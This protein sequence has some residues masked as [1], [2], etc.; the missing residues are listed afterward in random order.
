VRVAVVGATGLVGTHLVVAL[1]GCGD[2]VIALSRRSTSVAG[3]ATTPWDPTRGPFPEAAREGVDAVVNLAGEPL[4]VGRWSA[5]RRARILDSRLAATRG[6]VAALGDPGPT[7]LLNAS[8]VGV[9]GEAEAPV[10]E[11]AAPGTDFLA[12]V[13]VQ[14]EQAARLG[15]GRARVALM[16]LGV[17]LSVDGGALRP[18][19][20]AARL[21]VLGTI[22]S[23][24]QWVPWVHIDDVVAALAHCL[25]HEGIRGPVNVVA[26]QPVRQAALARAI[27]QA[28]HRPPTLPAPSFLVRAALGEAAS[29][30]LSGQQVVPA[31]LAGS[32]FDF[33]H[34][35][36]GAALDALL[37]R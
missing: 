17:V 20:R 13:C 27:C 31:A 33:A 22:G 3:V 1:R 8:A 29:L 36:L 24:R 18:L 11:L 34:R 32:D 21:G 37:A 30:V 26:P 15:D 5:A 14:W 10:D 19:L 9:Y 12:G 16:R 4:T 25:H 7:V 6:V 23:G 28:V 35:S 2:E